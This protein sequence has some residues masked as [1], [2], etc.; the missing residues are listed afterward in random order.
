MRI[1][2]IA[3]RK[4]EDRGLVRVKASRLTKAFKKARLILG[5]EEAWAFTAAAPL[6]IIARG[7]ARPEKGEPE[8]EPPEGSRTSAAE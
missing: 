1:W 2:Y 7:E 5:Y 8:R 6:E 4:G 3:F